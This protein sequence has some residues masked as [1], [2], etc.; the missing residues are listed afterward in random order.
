MTLDDYFHIDGKH[1]LNLKFGVS[2]DQRQASGK[3]VVAGVQLSSTNHRNPAEFKIKEDDY[4][5]QLVR[6]L[7]SSDLYWGGIPF[8]RVPDWLVEH[9]QSVEGKHV[10]SLGAC[11]NF[12]NINEDHRTVQLYRSMDASGKIYFH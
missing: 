8:S 3:Q 10:R 6:N 2:I 4:G 12:L 7:R 9:L 11:L 5:K 1:Q